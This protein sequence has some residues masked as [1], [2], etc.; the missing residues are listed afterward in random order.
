MAVVA[1]FYVQELTQYAYDP[2]SLRVT[3]QAVSRG[4][5]NKEWATATP[6]GQLSMSVKNSAAAD[7]FRERLGKEVA[8]QFDDATPLE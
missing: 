7:W 5:E 2:G 1:R 8:I 3:L 6:S 4:P